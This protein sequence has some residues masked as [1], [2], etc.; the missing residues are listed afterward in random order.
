[1]ALH[2]LRF[3][4]RPTAGTSANTYNANALTLRTQ[5]DIREKL[6]YHFDGYYG[7]EHANPGDDQAIWGAS[8]RV[9]YE[10]V[11]RIE[12]EGGYGYFSS[13]TASSGGFARGTALAGLRFVW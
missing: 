11:D 7:V 1:V 9:T 8:S 6:N 10:V 13:A 2:D 12:L 4:R 3:R 5:G